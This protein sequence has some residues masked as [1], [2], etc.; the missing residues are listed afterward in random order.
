M[1]KKTKTY[2]NKFEQMLEYQLEGQVFRSLLNHI[3]EGHSLSSFYYVGDGF[4]I[5][6]YSI[7]P[8]IKKYP[9]IFPVDEIEFAKAQGYKKWETKVFEASLG[10]YP[11]CNP[12][13]LQLIMRNKYKWD[14]KEEE[15][16]KE[17]IHVSVNMVP[18][19]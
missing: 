12:I 7:E 3:A 13:L 8:H 5:C 18:K 4:R 17:P 6:Y 10:K 16:S 1:T 14:S 15:K 9:D 19:K 11:G 2:K